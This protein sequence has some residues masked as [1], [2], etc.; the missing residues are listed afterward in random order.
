[1]SDSTRLENIVCIRLDNMGDLLMSSP[2]INA[3][4]ETF[5][6]RITLLTS[7][8]AAL[9]AR[10]IPSVDEVIT[11]SAPWVK[12]DES[13]SVASLFE[14]VEILK[15]KKFDAAV[16][17]T[18]FSQNPLPAILLAYM[19]NIPLRLA[20]CR[21]NP[22]QL[23]TH[24]IPDEEPYY[25]IRHQ[26]RRDLDMVKVIGA[27][28]KD[29]RIR[30]SVSGCAW[31]SAR[32]KLE[33][34]GVDVRNPW[35]LFH[36]GVSEQRREYPQEQW[37]ETGKTIKKRLGHQVVLTGMQNHRMITEKIKA[38]IGEGAYTMAGLFT[39]EEFIMVIKHALLVISVNTSTIHIAAATG[40]PVIV[41]YA[42]TNPQHTPWKVPARV[43]PFHVPE[44]RQSRNEILRY[45]RDNYL[46]Q[47]MPMVS[48]DQ[49]VLAAEQLLPE[50]TI[51][52]AAK[53]A[54]SY[55]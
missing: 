55:K 14:I 29:E 43:L 17:F 33:E 28:V 9:V 8:V 1:M 49:I 2:A 21:E 23:L 30:L 34:A 41:L 4:K 42:L 27:A 40:T 12:L 10:F 3:L 6:S 15:Q 36:P 52:D 31:E 19:A 50:K 38:G 47:E 39:I 53:E 25:F 51:D 11:F 18:V 32:Q 22:Y 20:Y 16:V 35:I 7:P 44:F 45:V 46:P 48:P 54:S 26:V 24:W 13:P 5:R 37:I